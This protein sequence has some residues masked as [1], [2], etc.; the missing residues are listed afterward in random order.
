MIIEKLRG[1]MQFNAM[2]GNAMQRNAMQCNAMRGNAMQC[3]AVQCNATLQSNAA[4]QSCNA[5]LSAGGSPVTHLRTVTQVENRHCTFLV[6]VWL[7]DRMTGTGRQAGRHVM[8]WVPS[9]N[10]ATTK[11]SFVR[12]E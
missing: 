12:D 4:W 7:L 6:C 9:C 8:V 5:L 10:A 1:A 11:T 2:Q 3:D